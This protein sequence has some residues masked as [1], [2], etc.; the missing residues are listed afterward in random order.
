M[1][2]SSRLLVDE[3]TLFTNRRESRRR[4]LEIKGWE[5]MNM[6]PKDVLLDEFSRRNL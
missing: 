6:K 4:S 3:M 5:V 1:N 2:M